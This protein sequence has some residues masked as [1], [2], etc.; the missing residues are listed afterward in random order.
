[1]SPPSNHKSVLYLGAAI[2]S[3][4]LLPPGTVGVHSCLTFSPK[5]QI[6][7]LNLLLHNNVLF[8]L[9]PDLKHLSIYI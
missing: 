4:F 9:I 5:Q 8:I 3:T 2:L 6:I 1:M 7:Q